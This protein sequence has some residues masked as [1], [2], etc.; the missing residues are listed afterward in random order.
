MSVDQVLG[1]LH[2]DTDD[3]EVGGGGGRGAGRELTD[4]PAEP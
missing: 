4:R 1:L 2:K 3:S